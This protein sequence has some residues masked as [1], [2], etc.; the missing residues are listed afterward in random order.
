MIKKCIAAA[1][2]GLAF[3]FGNIGLTF[4]ASPASGQLVKA[5]EEF[6]RQNNFTAQE[7][8]DD[9]ESE[10]GTTFDNGVDD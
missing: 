3:A 5:D 7:G 10:D 2:C 6:G 9:E 8:A 1:F 4:A